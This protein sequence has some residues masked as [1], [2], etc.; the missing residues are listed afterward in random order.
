MPIQVPM[1]KWQVLQDLGVS[2]GF[3]TVSSLCGSKGS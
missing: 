3:K 1:V 2:P